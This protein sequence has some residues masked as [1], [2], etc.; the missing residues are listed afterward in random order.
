[1][2]CCRVHITYRYIPFISIVQVYITFSYQEE[3][4]TYFGYAVLVH[5]NITYSMFKYNVIK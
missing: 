4:F 1:M 2:Y 5:W 3:Y